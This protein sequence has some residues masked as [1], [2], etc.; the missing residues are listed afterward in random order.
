MIE[1]DQGLRANVRPGSVDPRAQQR[2]IYP[3][4]AFEFDDPNR[5]E[6][7]KLRMKDPWTFAVS[8]LSIEDSTT[9]EEVGYI[10]Q[11]PALSL[12]PDETCNS[13]INPIVYD[14]YEF[15]GAYYRA[16]GATSWTLMGPWG[17][18]GGY[19]FLGLD[20]NAG[21][22]WYLDD[23]IPAI[24]KVDMSTKTRSNVISTSAFD[25]I[26]FYEGIFL[27]NKVYALLLLE[28][29][30]GYSYIYATAA[31]SSGNRYI[32]GYNLGATYQQRSIF[33]KALSATTFGF[34]ITVPSSNTYLPFTFTASTGT[35]AMGSPQGFL[36]DIPRHNNKTVY[37]TSNTFFIKESDT[38]EYN[39]FIGENRSTNDVY[40][41]IYD[42]DG[43]EVFDKQLEY[44]TQGLTTSASISD[45]TD[46]NVNILGYDASAGK[47]LA[48]GEEGIYLRTS[49]PD[50]G[51]IVSQVYEIDSF[52]GFISKTG[53][54]N[55]GFS[56]VGGVV[57]NTSELYLS[58]I[59]IAKENFGSFS[60][61]SDRFSVFTYRSLTA[62]ED[63][64]LGGELKVKNLDT[65]EWL[66]SDYIGNTDTPSILA[67][68]IRV[69][70]NIDADDGSFN[71]LTFARGGGNT[72][73][74][75][76]LTVDGDFNASDLTVTGTLNAG[77]VTVTG[78]LTADNVIPTGGTTGQVLTK[79][80]AVDFDTSW[81]DV[82]VPDSTKVSKIVSTGGDGSIGFL[83]EDG[84]L[85]AQ[86][87]NSDTNNF[88][89]GIYPTTRAS[90]PVEIKPISIF[91]TTAVISGEIF[92]DACYTIG[93][94]IA[95]TSEGR[96]F[97]WGRNNAGQVGSGGT[98]DFA[99]LFLLDEDVSR[100]FQTRGVG[101]L[102]Y[103][104]RWFWERTDGTIWG[105]G[106]NKT[107]ALG[108]GS[109]TNQTSKTQIT[110]F[111]GSTVSNLWTFGGNEAFT[112]AQLS[113][114]TI[115]ACGENGEGNLGAG[116]TSRKTSFVD[117]TTA[118]GGTGAGEIT[119]IHGAT[120]DYNGTT[121]FAQ[122]ALAML[123]EDGNVR[124]CGYG[125]LG[126][127]GDGGTGNESTPHTITGAWTGTPRELV[128][129]GGSRY[130]TLAVVTDD[131]ELWRWGSNARGQLGTNNTT[132]QNSPYHAGD[133]RDTNVDKILNAP[134][135]N[136]ESDSYGIPLYFKQKDGLVR[137]AG[138]GGGYILSYGYISADQDEYMPTQIP[139]TTETIVVIGPSEGTFSA[140]ALT[141]EGSIYAW[142]ANNSRSIHPEAT[143]TGDVSTP[144]KVVIPPAG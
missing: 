103:D 110:Y 75:E 142:G 76:D 65:E 27:G 69:S 33:G 72:L 120:M 85:I 32:D 118:W 115:V 8:R 88:N 98:I 12:I 137:A 129:I 84:R 77:D 28:N 93:S 55:L 94:S 7:P 59:L 133:E 9:E 53:L 125:G 13:V 66:V 6:N 122:S 82:E 121:S 116:D 50:N 141:S 71:N 104:V 24:H 1:K 96:L 3:L 91:S 39:G 26:I 74:V 19:Y 21:V 63:F 92:I 79:D 87:G 113:D 43:T 131:D 57:I 128:G 14:G 61:F 139:S 126:F 80:T 134:S 130:C 4:Q 5:T 38:V 112:V 81:A 124:T 20:R 101:R 54:E 36:Y 111:S 45:W 70:A 42:I 10:G 46:S 52:G 135:Q 132:Q 144:Y 41:E 95:L 31:D 2:T 90:G 99:G 37:Y 106:D 60:L 48:L 140:F 49:S 109:T 83:T 105:V 143:L 68:D 51:E 25:E 108:I 17:T 58:F 73:K 138:D 64:G 11:A 127:I 34:C 114:N 30:G 78:T 35:F 62:S 107:G 44:D 40:I 86:M 56:G 102:L 15:T 16:V 29:S 100:I 123:R 23:V 89:A 117:V 18:G 47:V 97:S 119:H 67:K 136:A 22:Y